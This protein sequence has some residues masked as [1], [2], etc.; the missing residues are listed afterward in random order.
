[1]KLES[2]Y[3]NRTQYV[4]V[5]RKNLLGILQANEMEH[6]ISGRK[7]LLGLWKTRSLPQSFE[8]LCNP[9]RKL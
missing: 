9:D 8:I 5:P 7:R 2:G 1:M 6:G 4:E 3:G